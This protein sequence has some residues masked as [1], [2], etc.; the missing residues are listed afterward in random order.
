MCRYLGVRAVPLVVVLGTGIASCNR[1]R[2]CRDSGKQGG[3]AALAFVCH[4]T[5]VEVGSDRRIRVLLRNEM[6]KPIFLLCDGCS[7]G[8]RYRFAARGEVP[9]DGQLPS[10][11]QNFM[12]DHAFE[13]GE[14]NESL[15]LSADTG[16]YFLLQPHDS[17]HLT[18]DRSWLPFEV[19]LPQLTEQGRLVLS[20]DRGFTFYVVGE[21]E[22]RT[23]TAR[24][25]IC[26]EVVS[27]SGVG[28]DHEADEHLSV[29][30]PRLHLAGGGGQELPFWV[31]NISDTKVFL[32]ASE[33]TLSTY[34]YE[35]KGTRGRVLQRGSHRDPTSPSSKGPYFLLQPLENETSLSSESRVRFLV[36]LPATADAGELDVSLEREFTYYV[37][38]ETEPRLFRFRGNASV[39]ISSPSG[40]GATGRSE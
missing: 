31:R 6:V 32:L 18:D 15:V 20:I 40:S 17:E 29:A 34:S 5:R 26:L 38:G 8:Y 36:R 24:T 37:L 28:S 1:G 9:P 2:I 16:P 11:R 33:L 10:P 35:L 7:L 25:D 23:F 3:A 19:R 14:R 22:P 39:G 30:I 4:S 21:R 13:D 12:G 27:S